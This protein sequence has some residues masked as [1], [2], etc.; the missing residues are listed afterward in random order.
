MWLNSRQVVTMQQLLQRIRCCVIAMQQ[1]GA[2]MVDRE[3]EAQFSSS[4]QLDQAVRA[5]WAQQWLSVSPES[6]WQAW[7]DWAGNLAI[8]P[9]KRLDLA[10]LALEEWARLCYG[11]PQTQEAERLFQAPE[12]RQWPFTVMSAGFVAQQ[13]WWQAA[14]QGVPGVEKHHERLLGFWS[15]Q[16]L[17]MLSPANFFATNPIVLERTAKEGGANLVRGFQYL[18]EDVHAQLANKPPAGCEGYQVGRDVAVTAGKVVLRNQ[19]MEL[20]QYAPTTDKVHPEP[21]LIMPAWIMKYYILDLSPHNSLIKYLVDQGHTVFCVSWRNPDAGDR[22]LGMD[23]YVELGWRAALD[24]V[25]AIVPGQKVHAAGYCLGGTLLAIAAAA[26]ARDGDE[27]LASMTLLAAQTDFTEPGELALFIDEAQISLLEAQMAQQGYLRADQMAGAFL[28]LRSHDL[29]WS[30]MVNQYL[31]GER[32]PMSDLMAWNADATRMPARMHSQ[33]LRR[34]FLNNDLSESRY[35]VDGKPVSL[36]NLQVP[37]FCVGTLTDHV[38]PWQSVFKLH[39]HTAAEITFVLTSGGH[40]AGI[41]SEPGHPRRR[42]QLLTRSVGAQDVVAQQWQQEAEQR[43]GSWWPAW[44]EWLKNR[45]GT[46]IAPPRMGGT[47]GGPLYDA[48]GQ[49]VL[50]H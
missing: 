39:H 45:S 30:R 17:E 31:L 2:A 11:G 4:Q 24:A 44:G 9:G 1:K 14:T 38:A 40:N 6:Q 5:M 7:M 15:R 29:L 41:V 32:A 33:Y 16:W 37:I 13:R 50:G 34:L 35:P 42:Y 47:S 8:S 28:M 22:D 26:M 10:R 48:P 18:M 3:A 12:W 21:V 49:Y 36:L 19:L 46:P 27:R 20:I 43:Q 23:D 25:T